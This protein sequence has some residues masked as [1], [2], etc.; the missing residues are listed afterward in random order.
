ML[1]LYSAT[2]SLVEWLAI[3]GLTQCLLI[4]VYIFF[5]VRRWRQAALAIAYFLVLA[6]AFAFQFALRLSDFEPQIRL[7]LWFFWMAG[8]PLSY[9]LILQVARMIEL[10]S[11]RDFLALLPLPFSLVAVL[12]ARNATHFCG[13]DISL[14]AR[15]F[16]WL[17]ILG[18]AS[19]A[20][21]LLALWAHRGLFSDM[22][23]A[24]GG[25]ERYWL[26]L[27]L[28]L[29]NVFILA[30][31]FM[32]LFD[33]IE[34]AR[35]DSLLVTVGIAFVYLATTTLFRI[36]PPPVQ[37]G[38]RTQRWKAETLSDDEEAL[39]LKITDLMTLDK[40]YQEPAFS[41]SDLARELHVSETI[42][43]RVINSAF[44][45]SFPKLLNEFRVEDAKKMLENPDIAINVIATEAG[46]NSLA[47]FNRVFRE[48]TGKSPSSYRNEH[49][50]HVRPE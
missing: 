38:S 47:S 2:F 37:L 16:D 50:V 28:I 48:I 36:Y 33:K 5:R 3:T 44:G 32:Y 34:R 45:K 25:G 42:L 18:G 14:C 29:M 39:V 41:R 21:C 26:V 13:D 46:F 22:K 11:A 12:T 1:P 27:S 6:L 24:R 31:H 7:G 30:V 35:A 15:V 23:S 17:Y 19:G 43:S 10:P 49:Y 4:L 9:L 40:V 8:P 20:L